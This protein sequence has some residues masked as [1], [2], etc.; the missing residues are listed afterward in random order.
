MTEEQQ[1]PEGKRFIAKTIAGLEEVLAKE[2]ISLGAV[3][4]EVLNRA[5]GFTGDDRLLYKA[6]YC[7]RTALR[8]LSPVISFQMTDEDDLYSN[9]FEYPWEELMEVTQTLAVDAVVSD[10]ELTH[11]HYVSLRSKDAIVDR[12]R[13]V[14]LVRGVPV[15]LTEDPEL[16]VAPDQGS[17]PLGRFAVG[18]DR[19]M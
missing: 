9:I 17:R 18:P 8:I 11:S 2:L 5:V 15:E 12:F 19:R 1:I 16:R 10:S 6:N 7:S 4:V 14:R 13:L 3:E